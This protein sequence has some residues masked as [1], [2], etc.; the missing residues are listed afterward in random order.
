MHPKL[1]NRYLHIFLAPGSYSPKFITSRSPQ[2]TFGI[3][4]NETLK[5]LTP[6]NFTN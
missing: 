2:Y 6:G 4:P 3:R 5:N 1:Y